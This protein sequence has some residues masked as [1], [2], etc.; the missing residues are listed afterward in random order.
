MQKIKIYLILLAVL[1]F[2]GLGSLAFIVNTFA[3]DQAIYITLFYF[4][5]LLSGFAAAT[6]TG[7][8]IRR[9]IG[10]RELLNDYIGQATRQGFWL[11]LI[12]VIS[13]ILSHH[14]LFS[15]INAGLLV[16]TFI[17]FEF[18]LLTKNKSNDRES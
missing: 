11:A 17:F 12:L 16:L 2:L 18:Y 15:W 8:Y 14:G 7:F 6:L 4:L 13:L 3:P 5:I 10:Q 9:L 1:L